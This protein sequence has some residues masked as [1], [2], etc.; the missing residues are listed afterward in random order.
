MEKIFPKFPKMFKASNSNLELFKTWRNSAIDGSQLSL[1]FLPEAL[2]NKASTIDRSVTAFTA[3]ASLLLLKL[4]VPGVCF[5][6]PSIPIAF[7][8][9]PASDNA[10]IFG[11]LNQY[12]ASSAFL[13][14]LADFLGGLAFVML[15]AIGKRFLVQGLRSFRGVREVVLGEETRGGEDRDDGRRRRRGERNYDMI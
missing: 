5:L 14:M 8:T 7:A 13:Y 1:I 6:N 9:L 10:N 4:I 15:D 3:G 2:T 12:S 11:R